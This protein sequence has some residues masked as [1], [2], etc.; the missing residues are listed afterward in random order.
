VDVQKKVTKGEKGSRTY[1]GPE[2]PCNICHKRK[3]EGKKKKTSQTD[4]R[5]TEKSCNVL[6]SLGDEHRQ[7]ERGLSR[8]WATRKKR[9]KR[10]QRLD[11]GEPESPFKVTK[12]KK[13]RLYRGGGIPLKEKN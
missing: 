10:T 1:L 7:R 4:F 6:G 8:N 2:R 5:P 12:R 11:E 9:K 13:K 3:I